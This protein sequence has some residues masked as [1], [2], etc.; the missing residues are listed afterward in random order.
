MGV[1]AALAFAATAFAG[2]TTTIKPSG[3]FRTSQPVEFSTLEVQPQ[4]QGAAPFSTQE[5]HENPLVR[6]NDPGAVQNALRPGGIGS[7][8]RG[9]PGAK[10][11]GPVDFRYAP[12][13]CDMA[14]GP[15]FVVA[16]VNT[17]VGFF[18]KKGVMTFS[19]DLNGLNGGF[20]K[21]IQTAPVI[22]DP[23]V[24]YDPIARRF[25]LTII[26][27][28]FNTN[29]AGMLV[30]VSQDSNPNGVWR[31]YRIDNVMFVGFNPFW[32]DYPTVG[33][34]KDAII[35]SGNMFGFFGGFA[36]TQVFSVTKADLVA[37]LPAQV[38][39]FTVPTASTI[40]F[41]R[42]TDRGVTT[43]YGLSTGTTAN[44]AGTHFD[45]KAFAL[46]N[47]GSPGALLKT[48]TV[49]VPGYKL[50]QGPVS[51]KNATMDALDGR[52]YNAHYRYGHVV[53]AH[54]IGLTGRTGVGWYDI[55][56]TT[57]NPMLNTG[58]PTRTQS[59]QLISPTPSESYHM[60]AVNVNQYG[61]IS[62]LYSRSGPAIVADLVVSS[63]IKTDPLGTLSPPLLLDKSTG[64]GYFFFRWGDYFAVEIDP[65][66]DRTFWGLGMTGDP[67]GFWKTGFFS[68]T[69]TGSGVT[70]TPVPAD[71]IGVYVRSG[72]P[73]GTYVSGD[74]TNVATEDGTF[75]EVSSIQ[76]AQFGQLAAVEASFTVPSGTTQLKIN[77]RAASGVS[78]GTNLI[79][80]F[81][82]NTGLYENVGAMSL[83]ATGSAAQ[84]YTILPTTLTKYVNG[85]TG[86]LK[87]VIRAQI[88][89]KPPQNLMP[90][91]FT[92]DVDL[93]QLL[94][95]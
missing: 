11:A 32:L 26:E 85:G 50:P 78:G 75:Y 67:G 40:Q 77:L 76:D 38:T 65:N 82:W 52:L 2:T 29:E 71:S 45:L 47:P 39:R 72:T 22:S 56:M 23:K 48:T 24:M 83:S 88:S 94:A 3:S 44:L 28:N 9:I 25:F 80:L 31:K 89:K 33:F 5:E 17:T 27:I 35:I 18:S 13:D 14:V 46:L 84:Q 68:W 66:D 70:G 55:D 86:Q 43:A 34:T 91:P 60:P 36:G 92:Y 7:T 74:E 19:M 58:S 10:F 54:T 8:P 53:A 63:R 79:W 37:G 51:G 87:A 62:V 15:G 42:T 81:N 61:D 90:A 73:D 12:P 21:G 69:V 16:T 59:G 20:F 64:S 6:M 49:A 93:L 57:W 4:I 41:A 1:L 95:K 30:A